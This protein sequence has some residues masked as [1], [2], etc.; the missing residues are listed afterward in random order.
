MQTKNKE[1]QIDVT[2]S[3]YLL[4]HLEIRRG[5]KTG[6]FVTSDQTIFDSSI[7]VSPLS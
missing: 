7:L 1:T 5:L 2:L 6:K 4:E 3:I